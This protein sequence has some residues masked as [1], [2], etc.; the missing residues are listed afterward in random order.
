MPT[1]LPNQN[2]SGDIKELKDFF[3]R[4][5]STCLKSKNIKE[6]NVSIH[7]CRQLFFSQEEQIKSQREFIFFLR[8]ELESKQRV[9]DN[10]LRTLTVSLH[11]QPSMRD[12]RYFSSQS[13]KFNFT[14]NKLEKLVITINNNKEIFNAHKELSGDD[15]ETININ[16]ETIKDD[17][18]TNVYKINC[19]E[20]TD[21]N[22]V[23]NNTDLQVN[24]NNNESPSKDTPEHQ[25]KD[26][27]QEK[28]CTNVSQNAPPN[29]NETSKKITKKNKNSSPECKRIY[30]IGESILKHVQGYEISKSVENCK[31][32]V[33]SFS[34]A[35]IR[36]MQDYVKPSLRENPDQ[37]I[38]H[39]GTNDLA[40][41]KRPEQIAESIIGVATSLKSA[42]CYVLVSSITVRNDQHRKKVAEVN[43][44]KNK[45]K[46][47]K[48]YYINHDKKIT[49]KHLNGSKLH[50]N[51]KGTSILSNTFLEYISNALQ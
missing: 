10:L 14:Q 32:Y 33:K 23:N 42:I 11:T 37:I 12:E 44:E 27:D 17:I 18:Q 6:D 41:N 7:V 19:N 46:K 38:V 48:T 3:D 29:E 39:V 45:K 15:K 5:A 24:V 25:N 9:I 36:D 21:A 13:R 43:I 30:I 49:V 50:L 26:N 40:S 35:K 22:F 1:P 51:K 47:K 8:K 16:Q 31:T 34:C 20:G 4:R 2:I 28:I